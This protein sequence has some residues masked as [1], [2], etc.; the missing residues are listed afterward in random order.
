MADHLPVRSASPPALDRAATERVLARA[1]ELQVARAGVDDGLRE[2]DLLA[3]AR[4]AGLSPDHVRLALAEER[5]RAAAGRAPEGGFAAWAAGPGHV[6][7]ERVVAGTTAAALDA[8]GAWLEREECMRLARRVGEQAAWEPRRDVLGNLARGLRGGGSRALR[9]A[10]LVSAVALPAGEGRVLVRV[11]ADLTGARRQRLAAGAVAAGGGVAA[12][13]SIVG[14]GVVAHALLAVAAPV[15]VIP[16]LAGGAAAWALTRGQREAVARTRAALERL[17]D[18][19]ETR[20]AAGP[21]PAAS[22]AAG[23]ALLEVLDG[24][25]RALR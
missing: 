16:V 20:L 1:A 4:E 11:E 9:R 2:E 14:L 5:L 13:G 8:L 24:V 12:G 18:A 21:P 22:R 15:A 23:G 19:V 3:A 17:L 6:G 7:A 25:R 10:A